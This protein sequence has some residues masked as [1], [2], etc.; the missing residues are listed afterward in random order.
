[1]NRHENVAAGFLDDP[2]AYARLADSDRLSWPP[3]RSGQM[4]IRYEGTDPLGDQY[5]MEAVALAL[6]DANINSPTYKTA[7]AGKNTLAQLEAQIE[8][9]KTRREELH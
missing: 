5:R 3:G 2:V 1:T 8:G 9:G 4:V 6:Y 7:H